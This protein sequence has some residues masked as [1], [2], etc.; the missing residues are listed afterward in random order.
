MSTIASTKAKQTK[1]EKAFDTFYKKQY[2]KALGLFEAIASDKDLEPWEANRIN[3][4]IQICQQKND[5]KKNGGMPE[6]L[7]T[8]SVLMNEKKYDE[9][10]ALIGKLKLEKGDAL[11]LQAE[12]AAE[13]AQSEQALDLLKKAIEADGRNRGFA[14]NSPSFQELLNE[15]VFSFLKQKQN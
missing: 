10:L 7:G 15:E 13:Q 2:D 4:F 14:L 6:S 5:E 1:V 8:V 9:A 11:F 3:Q 12:I